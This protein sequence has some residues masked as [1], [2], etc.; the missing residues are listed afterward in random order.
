MKHTDQCVGEEEVTGCSGAYVVAPYTAKQ[1]LNFVLMYTRDKPLLSA[2]EIR[3]LIQAKK[4]YKR[5]PSMRHFRAVKSELDNHMDISRELQI[6]SM[7]G[8]IT[9]LKNIAHKA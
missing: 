1:V 8:Y 4:I 6:V 5:I 2:T 9:F 3:S 7:E